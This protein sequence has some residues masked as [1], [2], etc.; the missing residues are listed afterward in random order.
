[1]LPKWGIV[2]SLGCLR[3]LCGNPEETR[4]RIQCLCPALQEAW[5]RANHNAAHRLWK[6]IEDAS[7][8]RAVVTEQTAVGGLL[9]LPL[10]EDQV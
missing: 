7:R 4:S 5:I 9:G 6:G 8:G 3:S 10:T 2:P 1:M